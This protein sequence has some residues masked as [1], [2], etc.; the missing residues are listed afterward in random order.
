MATAA[1]YALMQWKWKTD[2]THAAYNAYQATGSIL[3]LKRTTSL[4]EQPTKT[5]VKNQQRASANKAEQWTRRKI[6]SNSSQP[7][8]MRALFQVS[9]DGDTVGH[10]RLF[11]KLFLWK[12]KLMIVF[13][14]TEIV[15]KR[16][17]VCILVTK[18][19]RYLP[20]SHD[21]IATN[22]YLMCDRIDDAHNAIRW[23][24]EQFRKCCGFFFSRRV[25]KHFF[26]KFK[27]ESVFSS[28]ID[29]ILS[30][31]CI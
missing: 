17:S 7:C 2:K 10:S 31:F 12:M 13:I 3:F 25:A 29:G 19:L 4:A 8:A 21:F 5:Y 30:I 16:I 26:V 24:T 20:S 15:P 9:G 27:F 22:E 1:A 28:E 11:F 18:I 6:V 23:W 14:A